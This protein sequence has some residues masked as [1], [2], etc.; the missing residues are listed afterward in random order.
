VAGRWSLV[1]RFDS[2]GRRLFVARRNDPTMRR[3]RALGDNERKVVALLAL[4]HSIKLCA[5]ELGLGQSTVSELASAGMRK[6]GV[7]SRL[8]LVELHGA[9]VELSE[10]AP[11][12]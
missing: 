6:L 4:G 5:Y 12:I 2:D 9:I 7:R 10:R 11:S 8:E 1:E 3:L